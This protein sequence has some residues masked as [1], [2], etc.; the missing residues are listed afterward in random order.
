[1]SDLQSKAVKGI[2]VLGAGKG[3]GRVIS[4]ANT[5]ILARILSPDDYGLMAM[6]MVV[7][8]FIAFFNEIGLG[9]AIIQRKDI[10]AKQ[11]NGA[12]S[13]SIVASILLYGLTY[14]LAP[15][16]GKF[17]NNPQIT[18]M[19]IILAISFVIGAFSTVSNALISKNMQFK[20]LAGIE[21]ITILL[22]A[23]VTLVLAMMGYKA[24]ALVYGFILAQLIRAIL[25]FVLAKW[26]PT[27][28]GEFKEA[29]SLIRFGLTVTYSRLT[30]Y[31]YTNAATFIIGKFSG[32]KQLGIYSMAIT[33]AGLPTEHLTS[34]IRQVASPVFAKLQDELEELNML[35]CGFTGGL[36]MITFP[37]LAGMAVTA[38]ELIP[39][40][41]GEQWLAVVFPMQALAVMGLLTSISPL[42][43]QALTSTGNVNITA[44]YTTLCS[45]VVP[46]AVF[47]GVLWDGINGV[48]LI[49]PAVYGVLLIVLLMLCR[50]YIQL[51]LLRY[52][53]VLI[54]PISGSIVMTLSVFSCNQLLAKQ[55]NI[56]ILFMVEVTVGILVYLWW[57][58]YIR[59]DGLEQLK[60]ILLKV[61]I[62]QE[63]L[64]RWPFTKIVDKSL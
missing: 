62:G 19:L 33:L 13:I 9:S 5:I 46:L 55:F 32:E 31:A 1:M 39:I 12:F 28:F 2:A 47:F 24:W 42:L 58:I 35:L 38:P 20:A 52:F 15:N 22:Q 4:F 27:K 8:G 53:S 25:V 63:K 23:I 50:A 51:N 59:Q 44:K 60:G 7:C 10:T 36:A 40:L 21:F 18:N 11:L 43:T 3:L 57:L 54:T 49:L 30:W 34:L 41:L 17:Y 16:V 45:I 6:A 14:L 48:A 26:R 61:G 37:V 29:I 56:L 64:A